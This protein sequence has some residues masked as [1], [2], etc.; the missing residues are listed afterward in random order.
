MTI[1][2]SHCSYRSVRQP[3]SVTSSRYTSGD[4]RAWMM[5][6]ASR[7]FSPGRRGM[8]EEDMT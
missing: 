1:E 4:M 6:A 8:I 3:L 2:V 5:S 7:S